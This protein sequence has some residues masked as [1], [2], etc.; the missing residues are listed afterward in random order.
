MNHGETKVAIV[1]A[2]NS[3]N[4]GGL[5]N[6]VKSLAFELNRLVKLKY[7]SFNDEFSNED[8]HTF[9]GL[10]MEIYDVV[11]PKSIGVSLNLGSKLKYF[12]PKIIHQQGVWMWFSLVVLSHKLRNTSTKTIITPRGMLDEWAI[13]NSSL[14]KK[15]VGNLYEYKNL[16]SADCIH[17]LC[18]SEYNAIRAF[19]LKNPVA[20]IPNG[21]NLPEIE[22]DRRFSKEGRKKLLF[23][24]RIHP[25]KGLINLIEALYLIKQKGENYFLNW[26]L[27]IAGWSQNNHQ[28][29]VERLVSK[30]DLQN[31]VKFVGPVFGKEKEDL[32]L[33]GDAFILPSYSEG[34]PMSILEAWAYKLPVLMTKE[35]NIDIAFEKSAAIELKLDSKSIY[36]EL[37][38][39][40]EMNKEELNQ[41]GE[42]GFDLVS[43]DFTWNKIAQDTNRLYEWLLNKGNKPSFVKID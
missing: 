40:F 22:V 42:N 4:A 35:C 23:I 10:D 7:F 24:G 43:S 2:T 33:S 1:T 12:S 16:E 18:K 3:R 41:I 34:L 14:K 38:H 20:I 15:I 19:G 30:Y 6:S 26:E 32:L 9:E 28:E 5:F 8:I 13:S 17:A 27:I 29:E 11:G 36:E 39:L 21:I 37:I 31:Y 25:K